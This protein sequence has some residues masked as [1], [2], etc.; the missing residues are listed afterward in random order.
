MAASLTVGVPAWA[1]KPAAERAA[2]LRAT[3]RTAANAGRHAKAA[4]AWRAAWDLTPG[5]PALACDIGRAELVTRNDIE[6]AVW[7]E[8]CYSLMAPRFGPDTLKQARQE[9]IDRAMARSRVVTLRI[10]VEPGSE[11]LIDGKRIEG[12]AP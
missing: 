12:K 3:G 2:T 11:F 1:E 8:R 6:A 7:T 10:D 4:Q 5:D 9:F